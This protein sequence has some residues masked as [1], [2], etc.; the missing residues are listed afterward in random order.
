MFTYFIFDA[1][2]RVMKYKKSKAKRLNDG[3]FFEMIVECLQRMLSP[4]GYKITPSKKFYDEKGNQVGE[5]DVVIEG[6]LNSQKIMV[7]V[8]CRDRKS[9]PGVEWIQQIIGRRITLAEFGFTHWIA[10]SRKG[11]AKTA[12]ALA[13]KHSI[14]LL[15]PGKV[16]P[17]DKD[18][19]G[20]HTFMHL[21]MEILQK[22]PI[23]FKSVM[24]WDEEKLTIEEV[25]QI[26]LEIKTN[27]PNINFSGEK[28]IPMSE[29]IKPFADKFYEEN[30]KLFKENSK[31]NHTFKFEKLD[32]EYNGKFFGF[33]GCEITVEF[34]FKTIKPD[35]QIMAF[36]IVDNEKKEKKILGIIGI[37]EYKS[38]LDIAYMMIGI[39]PNNPNNFVFF[40][41]DSKG[42]PIPNRTVIFNIPEFV[43]KIPSN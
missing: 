31:L 34:N 22:H 33:S 36:T 38:D 8:E 27:P 11:F 20:F 2:F 43:K 4:E 30:K 19:P 17:V 1:T 28:P 16:E 3:K 24:V 35:F 25:D 32:A 40:L 12:T 15:I 37:N 26:E 10:V 39:K 21:S 18:K 9:I 7:G 29:F 23:E 14:P 41:R 5:V 42:K 13:K 6:E